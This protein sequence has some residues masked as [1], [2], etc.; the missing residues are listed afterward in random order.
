MTPPDPPVVIPPI[1]PQDIE[2]A[3]CGAEKMAAAREN[4]NQRIARSGEVQFWKDG[5]GGVGVE[6]SATDTE[7]LGSIPKTSV[8]TKIF[9]SSHWFFSFNF[10]DTHLGRRTFISF[11]YSLLSHYLSFFPSSSSSS[12]LFLCVQDYKVNKC[13]FSIS[14][15]YL[16]DTVG[17]KHQ[18]DIV[19]VWSS[20]ARRILNNWQYTSKYNLFVF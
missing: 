8:F 17:S 3:V 14:V 4:V 12:L 11:L 9:Q 20:G 15:L 2:V 6:C 16:P 19:A 7:V 1:R 5:G 13:S 18:Y 10:W